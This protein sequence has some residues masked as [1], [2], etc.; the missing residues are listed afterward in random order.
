MEVRKNRRRHKKDPI[1]AATLHFRAHLVGYLSG[2]YG[3]RCITPRLQ[4]MNSPEMVVDAIDEVMAK[5]FDRN[6][7]ECLHDSDALIATP[8]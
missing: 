7:K 5:Q 1:E 3:W 2:M 4:S 6:E 8:A